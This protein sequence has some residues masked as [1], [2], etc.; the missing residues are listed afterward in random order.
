MIDKKLKDISNKFKIH[1]DIINRN[2]GTIK[3]YHTDENSFYIPN[4][5]MKQ[6]FEGVKEFDFFSPIKKLGGISKSNYYKRIL[7]LYETN[8]IKKR[9]DLY[10]DINPIDKDE[11]MLQYIQCRPNT[12]II[13]FWTTDSSQTI[14]NII[15]QLSMKGQ[16][17]Y[18]KNIELTGNG[19]KNLMF[20][21]SLY[22]G[23]NTESNKT[24]T[25][26][27]NIIE[28]KLE[29]MNIKKY[30]KNRVSILIFDNVKKISHNDLK[31]I[32]NIKEDNIYYTKN[33]NHAIE[34]AKT[35][36]N[37]N[38]LFLLDN[39]NM[40][41]YISKF[42]TI[43]FCKYETLRKFA[44]E[45][46]NLYD[47]NRLCLYGGVILN[48]FT[49]RKSNDIDGFII[50]FKEGQDKSL[51]ELI[52]TNFG[53]INTK[54]D[55][56][57]IGIEKS[58]NWEHSKIKHITELLKSAEIESL[59]DIVT[60]P[61]YHMYF[62]GLKIYNIDLEIVR[63]IN[64]VEYVYQDC[65]DFIM[66]YFYSRIL[67]G[68]YVFVDKNNKLVF[69]ERFGSKKIK[70]TP[71]LIKKIKNYIDSRYNINKSKQITEKIIDSMLK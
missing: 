37:E 10:D 40:R 64:R 49:L 42:M 16:V 47:I 44:Y 66:M 15:D 51:E 4:K 2:I 58:K 71:E 48:L 27:L 31:T 32:L 20:L 52:Y 57:T 12:I 8:I 18:Y 13:P 55:F 23:Q 1:E 22:T 25:E 45:E 59:T 17:Y 14:N 3:F 34:I 43:S 62:G 56:I 11:I 68:Q 30:S 63:K 6:M 35:I 19:I 53:D 36:L 46:L 29:K 61:K 5:I 24:N 33:F 65:A 9:L 67:M 26:K 50:G 21:Y 41:E 60:N 28:K 54:I 7:E 38:S 39:M 70:K 69:H